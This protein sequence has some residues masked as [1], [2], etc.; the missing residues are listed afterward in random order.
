MGTRLERISEMTSNSTQPMQ[1]RERSVY[2]VED[3]AFVIGVGR[4]TVYSLIRKGKLPVVRIGR[5]T[6]VRKETLYRFLESIET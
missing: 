2:S 5:R 3:A 4:T 6:L 1:Q